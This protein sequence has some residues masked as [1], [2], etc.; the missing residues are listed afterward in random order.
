MR[1][2]SLPPLEAR[3]NIDRLTYEILDHLSVTEK[4]YHH[5]DYT[6]PLVRE[7]A[8]RLST[9]HTPPA[10]VLIIGPNSL[11]PIVLL[12]L[13][14]KVDLWNFAEGILT[15]DLIPHVQRTIAPQQLTEAVSELLDESYDAIILPFILEILPTDP[16]PLL[17]AMRRALRPEGSFLLA[18]T[19]PARLRLRLLAVAGINPAVA[20]T[21][22]QLSLSWPTL[23]HQRYFYPEELSALITRARLQVRERSYVITQ[24]PYILVD[25]L[26]LGRFLRRQGAHWLMRLL[27]TTRHAVLLHLYP[28]V[29]DQREPH[30][31]PAVMPRVS[32][33][34]SAEEKEALRTALISLIEQDYPADRYEVVVM[35]T[36]HS[37]EVGA[38]IQHFSDTSK[39]CVRGLIVPN[40]EGP[41]ARNTAMA[42]ANTDICA[43]TDAFSRPP[44]A[45]IRT[46]VS[47][48]D[49]TTGAVTGPVLEEPGSYSSSLVLPG[50]RPMQWQ[51]HGL[52]PICNVAY[53]RHLVMA[54]G[55]FDITAMNGHGAPALYWDTELAYRVQRLGWQARFDKELFL[56]RRYLPP[57][58]FSWVKAEWQ[59]AQ[60]LPSALARVPEL[61]PLLPKPGQFVAKQALYLVLLVLGVGDMLSRRRWRWLLLGLPWLA[62][63]RQHIQF[64]PASSWV[65]SLRFIAGLNLRHVLWLGG[66]ARGV[67]KARRLVP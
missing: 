62:R 7:L 49:D 67:I 48:F 41:A 60:H 55:G 37:P 43:H 24:N 46:L 4:Q 59:L 23:S 28:R 3:P 30:D 25:Y 16:L 13:G 27:P 6:S 57:E 44:A 18:T 56:V 21:S 1:E 9:A 50:T 20:M 61:E 31:L 52:Y 17:Q 63:Y 38:V 26:N 12:R 36:G 10:R 19:N 53:R 8:T 33:I 29:E 2:T 47:A 66:I 11:L 34:L 39:V 35:H 45:W 42:N 51:H 64:W 65:S 54:A 58:R 15:S 40:P 32:V 22:S 14:Y 5:L